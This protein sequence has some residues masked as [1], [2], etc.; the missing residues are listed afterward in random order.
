MYIQEYKHYSIYRWCWSSQPNQILDS[1]TA[2]DRWRPIM[3]LFWE[4]THW[5]THQCSPKIAFSTVSKL[6]CSQVA[7][8]KAIT[9]R[10]MLNKASRYTTL[11]TFTAW[12]TTTSI[13][14]PC[15]RQAKLFD[16]R[17]SGSLTSS[18]QTQIAQIYGQRKHGKICVNVNPVQQQHGGV[19]CGLFAIAFATELAHSK[20]PAGFLA[21]GKGSIFLFSRL[22]KKWSLIALCA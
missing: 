9:L 13:Q 11:G 3:H 12:V 14:L 22:S 20:N 17:S 1:G 15:S 10:K 8:H 21:C 5:C 7:F 18:L 4:S 19:D 6:V 16:S 2:S